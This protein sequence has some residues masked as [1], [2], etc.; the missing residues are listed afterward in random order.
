MLKKD[1]VPHLNL[2]IDLL[3]NNDLDVPPKKV[4]KSQNTRNSKR[5]GTSRD[6]CTKDG[7]SEWTWQ[8]IRNSSNSYWER[9]IAWNLF[10]F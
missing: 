4:S 6:N 9:V 1:A 10:K 2:T 5:V 7:N 3:E 8:V